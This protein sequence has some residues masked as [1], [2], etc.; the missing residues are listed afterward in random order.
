MSDIKAHVVVIKL[1]AKHR[2]H[3]ASVLLFDTVQY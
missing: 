2:F 3:A 1:K